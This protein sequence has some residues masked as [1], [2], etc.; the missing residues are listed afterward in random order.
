MNHQKAFPKLIMARYRFLKSVPTRNDTNTEFESPMRQEAGE[1]TELHRQQ[2][3]GSPIKA[4]F[5]R[6][7]E[8]GSGNDSPIYKKSSEGFGQLETNFRGYIEFEFPFFHRAY[9][10]KKAMELFEQKI[11][12][13][14]NNKKE[15]PR[16]WRRK[17]KVEQDVIPAMGMS[18]MTTTLG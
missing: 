5:E 13:Y 4:R 3:A 11:H 1:T 16:E 6:E 15:Q 2:G 12:F 14:R 9:G 10:L 8:M 7:A 17:R 18:D